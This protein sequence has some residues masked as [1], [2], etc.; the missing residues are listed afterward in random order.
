MKIVVDSN[1]V[2]SAFLNPMS[3]V[4]DILLNSQDQLNFF[5]C[6]YLKEEID[7]HTSEILAKTGYTYSEFK[8][9][10]F[11]IYQRITFFTESLI[12]FEVWRKAAD[13]VRDI[14]MNDI[15]F[16]SLSLFLDMKI[17][18]GDKKLRNG[19]T[20]KGFNRFITTQE[21]LQYRS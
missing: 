14:D 10:E 12:P 6:N 16:V 15:A 7:A 21:L 17:W 1:I 11:L 9:I 5:T 3:S 18:T 8:E 20:A 19:L 4:G 13:L 2:F